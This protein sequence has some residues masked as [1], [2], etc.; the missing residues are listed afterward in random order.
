MS[1]PPLARCLP[2]PPALNLFD[3]GFI[4]NDHLGVNI[5]QEKHFWLQGNCRCIKE[6]S[7]EKDNLIPRLLATLEDPEMAHS[8]EEREEKSKVEKLMIT[9]FPESR[10]EAHLRPWIRERENFIIAY[11]CGVLILN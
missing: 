7:Q 9:S 11:K 6:I 5:Q 8:G 10:F 2:S 3:K 4:Q 1:P